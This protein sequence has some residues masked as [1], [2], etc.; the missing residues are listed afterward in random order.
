MES[1]IGY[2]TP[3]REVFSMSLDT[4]IGGFAALSLAVGVL[5]LLNP[6]A[7]AV[8]KETDELD[9]IKWSVATVVSFLPYFNWTV[10]DSSS[11]DP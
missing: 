1:F 3:T 6:N 2:I 11:F 5:P 8:K 7:K 9:D 4:F 10:S